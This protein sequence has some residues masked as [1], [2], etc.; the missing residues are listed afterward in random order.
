VI[1]I[2]V[3]AIVAV[4]ATAACLYLLVLT[5]LSGR[6]SSPARSSRTPFFDV[7]VPAHN[8]ATG[9][10]KTISSLQQLDWPADRFRIVVVA[11]NC[12]DET[13]SIARVAGAT[14]LER[15]DS[16]RLGKG[17][18]LAHAFTWSRSSGLAAA[19]VIVDA[20]SVASA[21]LLE[22]FAARIEAGECAL[23]AHYGV[24]NTMQS[25]RTRLMAIALGCF[26]KVRSRARERMGLSCGIRGNGWCVTHA[27]LEKVPYESFSLTEDIEFG[28]AV[29]LAGHRVVYS[30]ESHV[31]GE[32]VTT[33]SAARSQRQRWEGG[34]LEL[35]R[36]KLSALLRAAVGR[37]SRVCLDLAFD[38]L[39]PPLSYVVLN[40][41]AVLILAL[42]G[43]GGLREALLV[44]GLLDVAALVLY[45]ARGWMVSETGLVGLGDLLRV[46]FFL[47]W[48]IVI[49]RI[50]PKPR[51]WVRTQR[52]R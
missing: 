44:V 38:L 29:G 12:T 46:P 13:A 19:V 30:D 1:G 40:V 5:C 7:I 20:D 28:I 33:E 3:A 39:L 15:Q 48:K 23:Q 24:L 22:S 32:M 34:R 50:Q 49:V 18:A 9:I 25:W 31:N 27:L 41:V 4:P 42:L 14:V 2:L 35:I 16:T 45:V 17:Y 21:N 43:L 11:D 52:E 10:A 6:S 51:T 47:L 26:H 36:S 8:E 37:P